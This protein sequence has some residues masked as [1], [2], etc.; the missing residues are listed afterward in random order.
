MWESVCS[1][2]T[3]IAEDSVCQKNG[4]YGPATGEEANFEQLMVTMLDER[5]KL[6][7]TI[8]ETQAKLGDSQ[9]KMVQLEKER[10]LLKVLIDSST[11]KDYT[12]L[13][14]EL[15]QTKEKLSEKNEEIS[16]LKAERSNTRLLLEHL[17]CLV[18]R[19]EKSLKVTVVKRQ[20]DQANRSGHNGVSSEYEILN[21]LKSLFEHHKALRLYGQRGEHL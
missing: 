4:M 21:A 8:R 15:N 7:E 12:F 11:P 13:M 14:Q 19:H 2:M 10:D 5:D 17:E 1:Q 16:E 6:M 9:T 20:Q 3:P 18:A